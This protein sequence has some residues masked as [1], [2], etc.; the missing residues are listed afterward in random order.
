MSES[1]TLQ[2]FSITVTGITGRT[3]S[4]DTRQNVKKRIAE[5]RYLKNPPPDS[6]RLA[7]AGS[8]EISA[9]ENLYIGD[10]SDRIYPNSKNEEGAE[11]IYT[12][13]PIGI[14]HKNVLVTQKFAVSN[15]TLP[16][17]YKCVLSPEI[18]FNS[19]RIFDKN[20]AEVS[21]DHYLIEWIVE[22]DESTGMPVSPTNY[23]AIHVYNSLESSFDSTTGEY[24]VYYIQYLDEYGKL[25]TILLSNEPAYREATVEDIWSVTLDIAPWALA[26]IVEISSGSYFL[27]VP[28]IG[29]KYAVK[30]TSRSRICVETPSLTDDTSVWYPRVA[31]GGF[32]W[33]YGADPTFHGYTYEITE[34]S[35]QSFNPTEP[36]KKATYVSCTMIADKLLSLPHKEITVGGWYSPLSLI[37]ENEGITTYALTTDLTIVG[38]RYKNIEGQDILGEDGEYVVWSADEILSVDCLAGI[39]QLSISI[40]DYWDIKAIY[41]YKEGYYEVASVNMNPIFDS[42]ISKQIRVLYLVPKALPNNNFS[43][44]SAIQSLRVGPSG[45][46]E[47]VS[48]DVD[49]GNEDLKFDAIVADPDARSIV[50]VMGLHYNWRATTNITDTCTLGPG[51]I[52]PV[53]STER[54][55]W[56]G[57]IRVQD[58]SGYWVYSKFVSKTST[59]LILS[60]DADCLPT[61]TPSILATARVEVA[62]FIDERTVQ[63][64]RIPVDELGSI[65]SPVTIPVCYS[66]YLILAE[67]TINPNQSYRDIVLLDVREEG[68]GIS[69][70]KYEEAKLKNPEVQW[71]YDYLR[72]N[73]Q[74]TPGNAVDIIKIPISVLNRFTKEQVEAIVADNVPLGILPIIRYYGYTPKITSLLAEGTTITIEWDKMGDEFSYNVWYATDKDGPWWQHNRIRIP[75]ASAYFGVNSYIL[76]DLA[77]NTIYYVRVTC[78]DRYGCW[79]CSYDS[80]DSISG[81][82]GNYDDA[83]IPPLGNNQSFSVTVN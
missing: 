71:Y 59:S 58:N 76:D 5:I 4:S 81:G 73:G 7:Y 9:R 46:I 28:P 33:R 48:Q 69:P 77:A 16:L 54:F 34:F 47:E 12:V 30:Y 74:P 3:I 37:I 31:N 27:R 29:G 72:Y 1:T 8:K 6:T 83:P 64:S 51:E 19:I 15:T 14:R 80:Y 45:L 66:Q 44:V 56:S 75:E 52:I 68:G 21:D 67:M 50:G 57:W 42:N 36:Y 40:K 2:G 23:T 70:E 43:Q 79:W 49:T 13:S 20:Y 65:V 41:S 22:Y 11:F 32:S 60:S 53:E 39:I 10:R 61:S 26:Y 62:N 78:I 25:Q 63:T 55:P 38:Q 18:D 82:Y 35:N 24:I 17:Y